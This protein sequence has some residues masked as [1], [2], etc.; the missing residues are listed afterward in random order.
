MLIQPRHAAGNGA[1]AS[2]QMQANGPA[3]RNGRIAVGRQMLQC[4]NGKRRSKFWPSGSPAAVT[5]GE[6]AVVRGGEEEK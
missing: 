6:V 1:S 4:T 5:S 2:V 3:K